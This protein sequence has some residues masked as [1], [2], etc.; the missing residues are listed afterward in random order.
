MKGIGYLHLNGVIHRD[1]KP[2]NI[3][4][5][6]GVLKIC[7][8]GWSAIT[9]SERKTFCGT[10]DY[11]SPEVAN[12]EKYDVK[13]DSWSVGVLLFEMLTGLPPYEAIR[14][15]C[16]KKPALDYRK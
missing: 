12:G 15:T 1:I 14:G 6:G 11:L 10:L 2:E 13:I 7:D 5:S 16:D 8:F 3:I 4:I 9:Y